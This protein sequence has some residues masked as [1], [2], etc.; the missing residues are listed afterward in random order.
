MAT[1]TQSVNGIENSD[2]FKR[3]MKIMEHSDDWISTG[4][5]EEQSDFQVKQRRQWKISLFSIQ[6][7][8]RQWYILITG[9]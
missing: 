7:I 5:R 1:I 6:T 3:M 2:I 4:W 9:S 8:K